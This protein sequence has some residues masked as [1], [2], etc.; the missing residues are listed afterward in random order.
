MSY[1]PSATSSPASAAARPRAEQLG[2]ILRAA[3]FGLLIAASAGAVTP[4]IEWNLLVNVTPMTPYTHPTSEDRI[5]VLLRGDHT[6]ACLGLTFEPPVVA[7]TTIRFAGHRVGPS[8]ECTPGSWIEE[9]E[10]PRLPVP[11]SGR[12]VT[13]TLE[14]YDEDLLIRSQPV[15]VFGPLRSLQFIL[16]PGDSNVLALF[17]SV[18]LTDPVAGVPR[19]AAAFQ[20]TPL[21]GYF[22]FFDP[23]N[24][25][26]TIKVLDGRP[27]NGHVWVFITGMSNLGYTITL[28][29]AESFP[30]GLSKTYVNPPGGQLLVIDV[31]TF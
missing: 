15:E 29:A 28:E 9:H 25:E 10:L 14:V 12:P 6:P 8:F 22:W 2:L 17:A 3:T 23:D 4:P 5:R 1:I 24:V 18:R 20:W 31:S 19:D 11:E 30:S 26:V 7:G 27:V 13:Y 21:A 16:P